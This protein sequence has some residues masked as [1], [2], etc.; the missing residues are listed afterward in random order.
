MH[1]IELKELVTY[2]FLTLTWS[3]AFTIVQR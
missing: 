2:L 1:N 3:L